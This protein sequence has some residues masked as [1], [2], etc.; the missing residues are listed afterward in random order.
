MPT[1]AIYY[2]GNG[3]LVTVTSQKVTGEYNITS[4]SDIRNSLKSFTRQGSVSTPD[5]PQIIIS[6]AHTP[7]TLHSPTSFS[8]PKY[9]NTALVPVQVHTSVIRKYEVKC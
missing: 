9:I 1:A 8:S 7:T 3:K 4:N 2:I 6:P 5:I